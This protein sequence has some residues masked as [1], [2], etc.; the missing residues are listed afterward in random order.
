M[1]GRRCR[2]STP[3]VGG[4]FLIDH[5][6]T[7]Q[8]NTMQLYTATQRRQENILELKGK[9]HQRCNLLHINDKDTKKTLKKQQV[10]M[11]IIWKLNVR[12]II[13]ALKRASFSDSQMC[14][15]QVRTFLYSRV[16]G[17]I[18]LYIC[19][20]WI[21]IQ[22]VT[23]RLYQLSLTGG[24]VSS[25]S[26]RSPLLSLHSFFARLVGSSSV[27]ESALVTPKTQAM[28]HTYDHLPQVLSK[29]I[30]FFFFFLKLLPLSQRV[31][32]FVFGYLSRLV[33]SLEL[34]YAAKGEKNLTLWRY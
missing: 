29:S 31:L 2:S 16:K 28:T 34:L 20:Y 21:V 9:R 11:Q 10:Q 4:C 12:L 22:C 19:I 18:C 30:D 8:A 24:K 32:F 27:Q 1:N 13:F 14:T 7:Q 5:F 23:F 33:T 6:K 25:S 3:I 15:K 17:W 26:S